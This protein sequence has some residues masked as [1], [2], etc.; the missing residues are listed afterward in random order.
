MSE[1]L[2]LLAGNYYTRYKGRLVCIDTGLQHT[3]DKFKFMPIEP[4]G[5]AMMDQELAI[6][7]ESYVKDNQPVYWNN[8]RGEL[9]EVVKLT[10]HQSVLEPSVIN[11]TPHVK[12]PNVQGMGHTVSHITAAS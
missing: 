8:H 12:V 3:I 6:F 9:L 5:I 10:A 4:Q 7:L 2:T 11:I 1:D